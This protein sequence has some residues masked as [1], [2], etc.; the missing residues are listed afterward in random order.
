MHCGHQQ[1]QPMP[2]PASANRSTHE[3]T[4]LASRVSP[5][6]RVGPLACGG[7]YQVCFALRLGQPGSLGMLGRRAL[8]QTAPEAQGSVGAQQ[9]HGRRSGPCRPR[10]AASAPCLQPSLR[11]AGVNPRHVVVRGGMRRPA[12]GRV[13]RVTSKHMALSE[14]TMYFACTL[15]CAVYREPS[16]LV[17][18][19][20]C[21]S[22]APHLEP[23]STPD[24]DNLMHN[25]I[26][27]T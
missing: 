24:I 6:H 7:L 5:C 27:T 22:L 19:G 11:T 1:P 4:H 10:P 20:A 3:L 16:A 25:G 18:S 26:S 13:Q 2:A 17:I 9:D 23:S 12:G 15:G 8:F 21:R 14:Y